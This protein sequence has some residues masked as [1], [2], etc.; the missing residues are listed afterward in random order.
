MNVKFTLTTSARLPEL[1]VTNGQLVYL[2]D[3]D[4]AYYDAGDERKRIGGVKKVSELPSTGREG[5]IYVVINASGKGDASIWDST[6][7][8]FVPLTGYAATASS[9]GLVK[10][11]GT[12]ITI[13]SNGVISSVG[14]S[15]DHV[16]YD[17]TTSG[18]TATTVQ[19]AIDE[20]VVRLQALEALMPWEGT[21]NAWDTLSAA[22]R[23]KYKVI[24]IIDE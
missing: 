18:L 5:T 3:L 23:A 8:S 21:R 20:L 6:T 13:D 19:S 16:T 15:A 12:S 22:D 1:S 10:P 11:D 24:N 14:G 17:N 4:E 7:S 2:Q 9:L